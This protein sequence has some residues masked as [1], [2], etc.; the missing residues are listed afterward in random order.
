MSYD[1]A[2]REMQMEAAKPVQQISGLHF[3]RPMRT[4]ILPDFELLAKIGVVNPVCF[5]GALRDIDHVLT[6]NDYDYI[7]GLP[8][9][10]LLS[11]FDA[12]LGRVISKLSSNLTDP[13]IEVR[14]FAHE[15]K[16]SLA[17]NHMGRRLDVGLLSSSPPSVEE[18]A[19]LASIGL[20]AIAVGPD[21]RI[22]ASKRYLQDKAN[23]T[24]SVCPSL[25][26]YE[27]KRALERLIV[28]HQRFPHY[29]PM[30]GAP[31]SETGAVPRPYFDY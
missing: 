17:F 1:E 28:L 22:F 4:A 7:G 27:Y 12:R 2:L 8:L 29:T 24:L 25:S 20:C 21:A 23:K 18:A 3:S 9:G 16:V 30:K 5:G 11:G 15:Q 6:P 31:A 26:D 19:D 10:H 14:I 13:K